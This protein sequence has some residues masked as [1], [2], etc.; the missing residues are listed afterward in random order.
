MLVGPDVL[1]WV[2]F[3]SYNAFRTHKKNPKGLQLFLFDW[4]WVYS[5]SV[6]VY[7]YILYHTKY[8]PEKKKSTRFY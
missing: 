2:E 6:R 7:I 3:D 1:W 5:P 4:C 8:H